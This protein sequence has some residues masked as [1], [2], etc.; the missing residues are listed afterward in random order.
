MVCVDTDV[1]ESFRELISECFNTKSLSDSFLWMFP[2]VAW[3]RE[4]E[5]ISGSAKC[6]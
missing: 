1:G 4:G 2:S 6:S 3:C 5:V